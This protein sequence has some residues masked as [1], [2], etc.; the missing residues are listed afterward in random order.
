MEV[1]KRKFVKSAVIRFQFC[2]TNASSERMP[3]LRY[4]TGWCVV[5]SVLAI[6]WCPVVVNCASSSNRRYDQY[7]DLDTRLENILV[8]D[9]VDLS[10]DGDA[11]LNQNNGIDMTRFTDVP[12]RSSQHRKRSSSGSGSVN[13][14]T[15]SESPYQILD[16]I[17]VNKGEEL[18]IEPGVTLKFDP[19]VGITVRGVLNA[20]VGKLSGC[21]DV[22]IGHGP[23]VLLAVDIMVVT[24]NI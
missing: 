18:T 22:Y 17:I 9:S 1:D 7:T 23:V 2:R 19:G 13:L 12:V 24:S 16:E 14:Y 10:F 6:A 8:G 11:N 20:K 5:A 21:C 3:S 4:F 15:R